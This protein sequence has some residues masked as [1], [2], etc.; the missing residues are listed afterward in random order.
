MKTPYIFLAGTLLAFSAPAASQDIFVSAEAAAVEA[1]SRDLD[2]KLA[3]AY[4]PR[5]Q[6]LGEGVAIVRFER[7]ADGLP[8]NVEI[9]RKS[10]NFGVDRLAR[11]A[12]SRLGRNAPLPHT[13]IPGQSYQANI[14]VAN[15]MKSHAELAAQLAKLEVKRLADPGERAVL[16]FTPAPRKES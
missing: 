10:G 8:I 2:R 12:V 1:V 7:G 4:T 14:I 15:S 16:A 6:P 13:G 11:H 3:A 5:T 9:Y